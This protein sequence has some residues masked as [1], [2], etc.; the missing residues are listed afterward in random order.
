LCPLSTLS[1]LQLFV[2][3]L[4]LRPPRFP[5]FGIPQTY[6]YADDAGLPLHYAV[7]EGL[8]R[9]I[10][11][12]QTEGGFNMQRQFYGDRGRRVASLIGGLVL[13]EF[14]VL[15]FLKLQFGFD[16]P[17]MWPLFLVIPGLTWTL[18][19]LFDISKSTKE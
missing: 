1:S 10:K 16:W 12:I 11:L 9:L 8:Q 19:T 5:S 14:G 7:V 2:Y 13:V 3:K 15:Q 18:S 17:Q 4:H 6:L